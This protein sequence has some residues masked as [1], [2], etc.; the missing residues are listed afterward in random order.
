M[1]SSSP[2]MMATPMPEY[3][4]AQNTVW[5]WLVGLKTKRGILW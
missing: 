1:I 4:F 5:V 2:N 3:V